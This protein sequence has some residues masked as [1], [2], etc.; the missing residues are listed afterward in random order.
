MGDSEDDPGAETQM[1]QAYVAGGDRPTGL[2]TSRFRAPVALAV[3]GAVA[4]V[5]VVVLILL[6]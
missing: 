3:V 2:P 5:I 6:G 4:L 1:F